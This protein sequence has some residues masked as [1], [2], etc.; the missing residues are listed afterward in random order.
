MD[1]IRLHP[2]DGD[3][4]SPSPYSEANPAPATALILDHEVPVPRPQ[5]P[6]EMLVRVEATTVV[7]DALTWPETYCRKYNILGNDFSGTVVS[8]S[9]DSPDSLFKP[10]DEVYGMTAASRAGTWAEYAV[11]SAEEAWWKPRSL[12]WAEAAAVPLSALTAYQALLDKAGIVPPDF[13]N[14][15]GVI[16]SRPGSGREK[17]GRLLVIGGAGCVGIYAVQLASLAGLYVV[18]ATRSRIRD[19]EFLKGLGADEVIE[20]GDLIKSSSTYETIIDT[21]GG[22]GLETCWSLVTECGTLISIDSAS[23]D[24]VRRH[25]ESGLASGKE[26]VKALFF[27]V[28]PS[29]TGLKQLAD[30]LDSALLKSFVARVMPLA[31][32]R[33]AYMYPSNAPAERGKVVLVPQHSRQIHT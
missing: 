5:Q 9:E 7:R 31:D 4:S 33:Q 16:R 28:H 15:H 17:K 26:A 12:S 19:E 25:R 13:S 3:S 22:K 30:A 14:T 24:F 11:V 23:Y 29:R 6:G 1:A 21:V 27:I 20:Y 8:L 18:A 32:A 2:N 10:G